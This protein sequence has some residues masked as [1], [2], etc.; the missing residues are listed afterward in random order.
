MSSESL[1]GWYLD[2][3][4]IIWWDDERDAS[5]APNRWTTSGISGLP[6]EDAVILEDAG[7]LTEAAGD[8]GGWL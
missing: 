8:D 3:F 2:W 1:Q 7:D 4:P 5:D 6:G